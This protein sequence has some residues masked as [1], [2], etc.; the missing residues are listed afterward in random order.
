MTAPHSAAPAPVPGMPREYLHSSLVD[1]LGLAIVT[2]EFPVGAV[3]SV[4][5]LESR[6]GVSR[7]VVRE[8][9]RVLSSL[10]LLASRRRL[11]TLVQPQSA[12]NLYDPHV[13]RWRLASGSRLEQLR[14]LGELRSAV[15][16]MAAKL[17][18]ARASFTQASDLVALSAKMWASGQASDLETFLKLDVEFHAK[19]LEASGNEMFAQLNSLVTEVLKGRIEHGLMPHSPNH[20]AMGFHSDVANAVQ[21]GNGDAAQA[22]MT[23]IV[24]QS[25]DEMGVIWSQ[26]HGVEEA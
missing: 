20:H 15:E 21:R 26:I 14:S 23:K 8:V 19:L 24:E 10:G 22:A 7:S 16:P 6:Y 5:E 3:L 2:G 13:I 4:E 17:A 1:K 11:G 25:M 18:A 9:I 12:W